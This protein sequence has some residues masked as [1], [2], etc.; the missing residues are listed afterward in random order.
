MH[1]QLQE[2]KVGQTEPFRLE[3][4]MTPQFTALNLHHG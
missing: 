4:G 1:A 2:A 3:W